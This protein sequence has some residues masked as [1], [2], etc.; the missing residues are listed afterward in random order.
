VYIG[1]VLYL[2]HV[3]RRSIDRESWS[4]IA[5]PA[6]QNHIPQLATGL[7]FGALVVALVFGFEYG[8]QWIQIVGSAG[9]GSAVTLLVDS[10]LLG[11]AFGA[12]EEICMRGY[13]FQNLGQGRPL[14]QATL[15]TGPIFGAF[16]L[17]SV[18]FGVRG[19]SFFIFALLLNVFLVLTRLA[20][21]SLWFAIGF[22][23]AFDWVAI[24][25]GLGSVVLAEQHLL[26]IT[27]AISLPAE[28][29]VTAAAVALG[30]ALLITWVRQR[31]RPFVWN[32]PLAED[33]Q[34][35]APDA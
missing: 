25:L 24:N 5:L 33:G 6:L 31:K 23:T 13:I 26:Q 3:Y 2:T 14:W 15:I 21:R 10:L 20:T 11:T 7:F 22:H 29:L 35:V 8:A 19:L 17:L 27:R 12:S 9:S 16:H 18:G 28:D 4:G 34:I 32:A 1:G 30:I